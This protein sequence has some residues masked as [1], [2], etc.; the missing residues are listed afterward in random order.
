MLEWAATVTARLTAATATTRVAVD[1]V[2][3]CA[4]WS[5]E[6]AVA[7]RASELLV[8]YISQAGAVV[9]LLSLRN[10]YL[11]RLPVGM[12]AYD[13]HGRLRLNLAGETL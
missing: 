10:C 8:R 9:P 3:Q 2:V 4:L 13:E 7:R 11:S 1:R 6:K 12:A 5:T